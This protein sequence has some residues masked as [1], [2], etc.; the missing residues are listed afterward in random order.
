MA[1]V[2]AA[3]AAVDE[4]QAA[5]MKQQAA[6]IPVPEDEAEKL[7]DLPAEDQAG[8]IIEA[9]EQVPQDS[10]SVNDIPAGEHVAGQDEMNGNVL[11][12]PEQEQEVPDDPMD[13]N[14]EMDDSQKS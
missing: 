7:F 6:E 5:A 14:R 9:P 4:E 1:V 3:V 2:F 12:D 10:D 13:E 11:P 8:N